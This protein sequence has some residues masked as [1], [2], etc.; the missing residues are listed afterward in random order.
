MTIGM[1]HKLKQKKTQWVFQA[2]VLIITGASYTTAYMNSQFTQV[3]KPFARA[4]TRTGWF[5][6]QHRFGSTKKHLDA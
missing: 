4:H 6:L 1:T 5:Q 3:L 2:I